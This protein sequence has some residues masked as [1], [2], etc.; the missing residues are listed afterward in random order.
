M[1]RFFISLL[2]LT[3]GCVCATAQVNLREGIVITLQGDTLH[4]DID[5]RT[6]AIN[7][8]KCVF[9]ANGET[10]YKTYLPGEIQGYRFK[11]NG[12]YYV[13]KVIGEN[14]VTGEKE[15]AF[16]EFVVKG[17]LSFYYMDALVTNYYFLEDENG[18]MAKFSTVDELAQPV[19]RRQ[20]LNDA[21]GMIHQSERAQ[22]LLWGTQTNK[23]NIKLLTLRYNKDV[24]PDGQCEVFEYRQKKLPK[25]DRS[26]RVT[27]KGGYSPVLFRLSNRAD[28]KS[29]LCNGFRISGG[30]DFYL[31]RLYPG[32]FVQGYV[33]YAQ[34]HS[35][36]LTKVHSLYK[37]YNY[38]E[39]SLKVGLG[40]EFSLFTD[41]LNA[42]FFVGKDGGEFFHKTRNYY[43]TASS[44]DF[45]L[46]RC[47]Y[48]GGGLS[49]PIGKHK[50]LLEGQFYYKV[51][52]N[53]YWPTRRPSI[54]VGYQF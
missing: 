54:M 18:K 30:A 10:Q 50:I 16:L 31:P 49:Y 44:H 53:E 23:K 15:S 14:S 3:L 46:G 52:E 24:C 28:S 41:K 29:T 2:T 36:N 20:Q 48:Y 42:R 22:K 47:F 21:F 7:A 51:R 39:L 17:T 5:Y 32:L 6:D 33:D 43:Y 11:D 9:I 37:E 12:R 19:V 40:Y 34:A 45:I 4:G 26:T 25:A 35:D 8:E 1:K 38:K 27:I 13:S